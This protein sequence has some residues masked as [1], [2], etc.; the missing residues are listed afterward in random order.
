MLSKEQKSLLISLLLG[1]GTISNNNVFK[2]SHSI[3]Q[4]DYL[5]WKLQLL[6]KYNI[7]H[8][9]IKEYTSSK[10][11]NKGKTVVYSQISINNTIKALRR[12]IYKPNKTITRN[13][14]NWL[15]PLGVY[16]WYLDD[17]SIN[18]NQ[19]K[20]RKTIQKTIKF[21]T[22]TN[23]NTTNIIIDYFKEVWNINFRKF[24]E[25]TNSYSIAS[26]TNEDCLKFINL[27]SPYIYEVPS[28][29][30]KFRNSLT[31]QEFIKLQQTKIDVRD[32]LI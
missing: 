30:Y 10:G 22:C 28:L 20:Q 7:K 13:L 18:I 26:R 5:K 6:D 25:G 21:A 11:Y 4:K 16:I 1:D 31:K 29:L 2:M 19:S 17:G 3:D 14:L 23:I 24:P 8:G 9:D 27:V 32:I 15:T 12:S